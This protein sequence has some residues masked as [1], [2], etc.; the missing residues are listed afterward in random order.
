MNCL[1]LCSFLFE[2][3]L[4]FIVRQTFIRIVSSAVVMSLVGCASGPQVVID[5]KSITDTAKYKADMDECTA[6][7][8]NYDLS[9]NTAANAAVGAV[10]GG[11][12]VAGV[13]TAVAGAVFLPALP[14]IVAGTLAGGG[15][16]GGHAKQKEAKAREHILSQC[17]VDRGYKAYTSS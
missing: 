15:A 13:A 12:A 7:A 2:N 3:N 17:M 11:A 9:G 4:E 1:R 10:A 14:F 16:L 8:K 6:I 5:P